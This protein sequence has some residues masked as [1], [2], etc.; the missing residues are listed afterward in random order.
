MWRQGRVQLAKRWPPRPLASG[1]VGRAPLQGPRVPMCQLGVPLLVAHAQRQPTLQPERAL[2]LNF[3]EDAQIL[4]FAI[5]R[6]V[7]LVSTM[8]RTCIELSPQ[9]SNF[10]PLHE[11]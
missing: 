9:N 3:R 2:K 10:A 7:V 8:W 5:R 4:N 11:I 6:R 1:V